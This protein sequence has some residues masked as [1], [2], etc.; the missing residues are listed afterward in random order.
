MNGILINNICCIP[1]VCCRFV[2]LQNG[3]EYG[4]VFSVSIQSSPL[5]YDSSGLGPLLF[6]AIVVLASEKNKMLKF[7][8]D[9]GGMTMMETMRR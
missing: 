6:A 4:C 7:S 1:Y 2:Y 5:R 3:Q 9:S 8:F